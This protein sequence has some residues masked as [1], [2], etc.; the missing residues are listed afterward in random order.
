MPARCDHAMMIGISIA[1]IGVLF[2]MLL[3]AVHGLS[4]C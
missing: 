1:T 4:F 2:R 3:S